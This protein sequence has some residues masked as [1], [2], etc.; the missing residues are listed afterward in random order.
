MRLPCRLIYNLFVIAK[1]VYVST[2]TLQTAPPPPPGSRQ[3]PPGPGYSG[4][5]MPPTGP[6]AAPPGPHRPQPMKAGPPMPPDA[7]QTG[8]MPPRQPGMP[9]HL[10]AMPP[11]GMNASV[12]PLASSF[13]RMQL[14]PN[15]VVNLLQ[16]RTFSRRQML[17][18]LGGLGKPIYSV[19]SYTKLLAD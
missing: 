6:G 11:P 2:C 8:P 9:N 19:T 13:N 5:P 17:S 1:P 7:S 3:P 15:R 16:V 12:G 4:P 10:P 18:A 14:G